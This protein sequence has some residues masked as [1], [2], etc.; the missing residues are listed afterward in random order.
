[1]ADPRAFIDQDWREFYGDVAEELPPKMPEPLGQSV[2][3]SCFVDANHAGNVVTHRLHTGILIY[4]QNTPII[5][6]SQ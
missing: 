6:H 4:V 3:V 1:M 5:W 2:N